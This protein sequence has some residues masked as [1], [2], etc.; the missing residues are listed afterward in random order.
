MQ[1]PWPN[2]GIL[3][4]CRI[5]K[6][7]RESLLETSLIYI[8][9]SFGSSRMGWDTN[10]CFIPAL[11]LG[12]MINTEKVCSP[13]SWIPEVRNNTSDSPILSFSTDASGRG[14]RPSEWEVSQMANRLSFGFPVTLRTEGCDISQEDVCARDPCLPLL[15]KS[16]THHTGAVKRC[17]W[18]LEMRS[19]EARSEKP[20]ITAAFEMWSHVTIHSFKTH[21]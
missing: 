11:S 4:N 7:T 16:F 3:K 12:V 5:S 18:T 17:S 20:Q 2:E 6:N 8:K 15:R 10:V 19:Q 14:F 21:F 13:C 9:Y 1:S